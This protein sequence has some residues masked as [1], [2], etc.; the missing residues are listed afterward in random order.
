MNLGNMEGR[1]ASWTGSHVHG[2]L[3]KMVIFLRTA[4]GVG[5]REGH[6]PG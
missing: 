2:R 3:T 1:I 6:L 5:E 4:E